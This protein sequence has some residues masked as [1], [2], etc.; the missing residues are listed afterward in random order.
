MVPCVGSIETCDCLTLQPAALLNPIQQQISET[1]SFNY[2][3]PK[4]GNKRLFINTLSDFHEIKIDLW[5][6]TSFLVD[7]R[8]WAFDFDASSVGRS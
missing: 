8:K 6:W 5:K 4:K 1:D 3:G 2:M 7:A